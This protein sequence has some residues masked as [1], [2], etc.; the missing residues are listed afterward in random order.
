MLP[1]HAYGSGS[2]QFWAA[3]DSER[4]TALW[5]HLGAIFFGFV[6]LIMYLVKKDESP[7]IREHSRQGLNAMITNTIITTG[8][9][10]R[11]RLL[12]VPAR[13]RDFRVRFPPHVC[14]IHRP[15]GLTSSSASSPPQRRT[16]VR[17]TGSRSPST[18]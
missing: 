3:S 11:L 15:R 5:R 12:R 8:A 7:Y 6:P 14:R 16:G 13:P 2:E 9:V 10:L 18:L 17:D 1:E 4:T